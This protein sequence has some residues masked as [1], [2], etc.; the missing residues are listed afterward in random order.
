MGPPPILLR[1]AKLSSNPTEAEKALEPA[2]ASLGV[3]YRFQYALWALRC[4]PDFALLQQRIVFEV[5]DPGHRRSD[6]KKAD[7]ERTKR[8]ENAGWTVVRT[9]N[10]EALKDP[11]EA[12][13]RML[14]A[15]GCNLRTRRPQ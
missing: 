12:V 11:Y 2:V 15:A 8:L 6:R 1:W 13:D 5:D 9:T 14:A 10:A 3:P 7:A 4:F